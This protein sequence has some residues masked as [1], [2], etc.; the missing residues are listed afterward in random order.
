MPKRRVKINMIFVF[1]FFSKSTKNHLADSLIIFAILIPRDYVALLY[2][3]TLVF[4]FHNSCLISRNLLNGLKTCWDVFQYMTGSENR[5]ACQDGDAA[6]SL[7]EGYSK[8]DFN[9]ALVSGFV[10]CLRLA[11][12]CEIYI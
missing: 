3:L 2:S 10:T 6:N 8:F 5:L 4:V 7:G 1:V 11:Y 12:D 9:G